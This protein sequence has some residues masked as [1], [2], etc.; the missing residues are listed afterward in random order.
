M[1]FKLEKFETEV[2]RY[3]S[4]PLSLLFSFSSC[5]LSCILSYDIWSIVTEDNA[6]IMES[7]RE[8]ESTRASLCDDVRRDRINAGHMPQVDRGEKWTTREGNCATKW[9]TVRGAAKTARL[10][11]I[12]VSEIIFHK[13]DVSWKGKKT[14][15]KGTTSYNSHETHSPRANALECTCENRFSGAIGAARREVRGDLSV[16]RSRPRCLVDSLTP[17]YVDGLTVNQQKW[18]K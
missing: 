12:A 1:S 5:F 6:I 16:G 18:T 13:R 8:I 10:K 14:K 4:F 3:I 11:S 9:R 7:A 17:V 15:I 2:Q